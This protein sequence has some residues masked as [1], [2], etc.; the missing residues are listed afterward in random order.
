MYDRKSEEGGNTS[1][2]MLQKKKSQR[3]KEDKG[4]QSVITQ[5]WKFSLHVWEVFNKKEWN[6]STY[7]NHKSYICHKTEPLSNN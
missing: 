7:P 1:L 5:L 2:G 3:E 6:G 4:Y